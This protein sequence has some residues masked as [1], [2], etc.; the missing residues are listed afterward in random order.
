MTNPIPY[1]LN[2]ANALKLLRDVAKD[3]GRVVLLPH[4]RKRMKERQITLA[5]V[6]T[7]LRT[8]SLAESAACDLYGNWKMTVKGMTCGQSIT[9]ACAIEMQEEPGK[10]V[11]VITLFGSD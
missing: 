3:S 8:A 1:R 7:V 11:L 9:A 5:Q 10:R 6:L 4:A 2:D